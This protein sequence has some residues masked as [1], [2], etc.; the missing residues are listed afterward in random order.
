VDGEEVNAG[1]EKEADEDGGDPRG[2][3]MKQPSLLDTK[4]VKVP[5]EVVFEKVGE[6][7]VLLELNLGKYFGL[8]DIGSRIWELLTESGDPQIVLARL[9]EEFDVSNEVV[10]VDLERL[11]NE[12][13]E[14]KLIA[15]SSQSDGEGDA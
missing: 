3:L 12:L 13:A 1:V 6:E 5:D 4:N 11:L 2:G 15:I 7:Y 14:K 10:T 9:L 8:N